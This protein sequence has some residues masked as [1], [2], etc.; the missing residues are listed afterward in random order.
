VRACAPFRVELERAL[1]GSRG[2][3]ARLGQHEHARA[4]AACRAEL[5]RERGLEVV[6]ERLPESEIPPALAR[7]VLARLAGEHGTGC[8]GLPEHGVL[9][10][11]ELDELLVRLPTPRAPAG[12]TAR[13]LQG[14]AE[15]REL[16][17]VK[18][19]RRSWWWS[20][21]AGLLVGLGFWGWSVFRP[22][23]PRVD[24][25]LGT[26]A[27]L[28]ADEELLTYAVE[29][30]ELLQDEDLDLWLASLDP[31]D[32][33]LIEYAADETWLDDGAHEAPVRKGE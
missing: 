17:R 5:R 24:L 9:E 16:R 4:C 25:A 15:A 26:G 32:E 21:A 12:L 27:E 1:A 29:R 14:V 28:E 20:V 18:S 22:A 2:A 7:R 13:V 8:A 33:L 30:W 31:V 19:V 11:G 10:D 23:A 6:L 3:L